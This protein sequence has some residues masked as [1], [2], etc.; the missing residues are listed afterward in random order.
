MNFTVWKCALTSDFWDLQ[1]ET[2][3][4]RCAEI[5]QAFRGVD[6]PQPPRIRSYAWISSWWRHVEAR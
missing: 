6:G 4:E 1:I 5:W 3:F 2:D